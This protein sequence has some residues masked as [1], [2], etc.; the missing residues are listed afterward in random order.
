MN[1]KSI[2]IT[3]L[4]IVM[5]TIISISGALAYFTTYVR[6][7]GPLPVHLKEK[8]EFHEDG[9]D[10][11]KIITIKVDAD[12]D[13]VYVRVIAFL[14]HGM[15]AVTDSE[16][17]T[18]KDGYYEYDEVLFANDE[19]VLNLCP[20]PLPEDIE[21]FK[22]AVAYEYIPAISDDAGGWLAPDWGG[23][24]QIIHDVVTGGQE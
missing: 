14:P 3:A 9:D 7:S 6:D 2:L 24:Q 8:I 12:S 21:E 19:A 16:G 18:L 15:E 17:W 22:M 20:Q 10:E 4:S 11:N 1:K 23:S 13:P 5:I